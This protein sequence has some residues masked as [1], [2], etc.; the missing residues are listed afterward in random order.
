MFIF[1]AVRK[2]EKDPQTTYTLSR[3]P[4]SSAKMTYILWQYSSFYCLAL[5]NIVVKLWLH[6]D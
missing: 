1:I 3:N 4:Y 5:F 2:I 6:L